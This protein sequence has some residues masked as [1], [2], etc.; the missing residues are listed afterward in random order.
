MENDRKIQMWMA[1]GFLVVIV[2][3]AVIAGMSSS[4]TVLPQGGFQATTVADIT[5]ADWVTGNKNAKVS[6][7]TYGDFQ[8]PACAAYEPI[9]QQLENEYASDVKFVF[10]NY[11]LPQHQNGVITSQAAE[12]AGLQGK[13]WEMHDLL[14]AK[15]TEWSDAAAGEI[16]SKYLNVY[17]QSL[18]LDVAKFNTDINSPA[19]KQK[20]QTDMATANAAKVDHTPTFFVNLRQIPNPQSAAAFKAVIDAALASS[21]AQQ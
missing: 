15:Q 11:P 1:G 8:C 2:A 14:Y 12:A 3:I 21:T 5:S 17:A 16:V 4:G 20:I 6:V 7:I 9:L 13:F 18:G 19:V 10:R